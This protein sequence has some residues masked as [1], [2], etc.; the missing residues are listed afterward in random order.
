MSALIDL[1]HLA[2]NLEL[3]AVGILEIEGDIAARAFASLERDGNVIC[4][5]VVTRFQDDID[6]VHLERQVFHLHAVFIGALALGFS[7]LETD[8]VM[9]GAT[10]EKH[11][12]VFVAVAFLEPHHL[13]PK[14]GRTLY[15]AHL[16]DHV[17]ELVDLDR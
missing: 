8:G 16:V 14:L 12:A 2:I 1:I 7:W 3:E 11:H 5:E 13:G 9:V 15:I 6:I 10:A 4:D 17:P